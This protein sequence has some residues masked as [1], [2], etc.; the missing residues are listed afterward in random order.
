VFTRLVLGILL[1]G[2]SRPNTDLGEVEE[3]EALRWGS[4]TKLI[5][6]LAIRPMNEI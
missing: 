5:E 3:L 1:T 2:F 4:I 6:A